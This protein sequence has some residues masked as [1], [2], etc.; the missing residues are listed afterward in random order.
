MQILAWVKK[1]PSDRITNKTKKTPNYFGIKDTLE[2]RAGSVRWPL[3]AYKHLCSHR[4]I[5]QKDTCCCSA[6][7]LDRRW[8]ATLLEG[9]LVAKTREEA[10]LEG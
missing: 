8:E 2:A 6:A 1:W 3:V 9:A 10:A 5:K 7:N 4:K